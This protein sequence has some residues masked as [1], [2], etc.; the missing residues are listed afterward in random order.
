M[1]KLWMFEWESNY[2]FIGGIFKATDEEVE[3]VIG[4]EIYLG[5]VDGK[6]SEVSGTIEREEITLISDDPIVVNAVPNFG[7]NPILY[8]SDN[9]E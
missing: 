2:S 9:T 6:Y 5:E 8:V 4:K 7:Y 3:N 1:L